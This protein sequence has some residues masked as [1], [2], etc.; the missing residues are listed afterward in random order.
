MNEE[1]KQILKNQMSIMIALRESNEISL[2][3]SNDVLLEEIGNTNM[4]LN[5]T[6]QPTI[7]ERTHDAL[8]DDLISEKG[9]VKNG[10]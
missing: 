2:T 4:I 1:T 10:N 8:S 6:I 3:V 5:P 9:D 7:K